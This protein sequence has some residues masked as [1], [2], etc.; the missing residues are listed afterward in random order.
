MEW[1]PFVS[2]HFDSKQL[3]P[4]R[5]NSEHLNSEHFN[6]AHLN[7]EHL[8]PEHVNTEQ[9]HRRMV[10]FPRERYGR[11]CDDAFIF[12]EAYCPT[13]LDT[14]TFLFEKYCPTDLHGLNQERIAWTIY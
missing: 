7:P 13:T 10:F 3:D 4:E 8:N 11:S 1:A 5:L 14:F 2:T 12:L 6:P 9:L